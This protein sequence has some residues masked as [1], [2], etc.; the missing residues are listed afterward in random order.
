MKC[1]SKRAKQKTWDR[2]SRASLEAH[3]FVYLLGSSLV[4][5][6]F[7]VWIQLSFTG[8]F[9]R[10]PVPSRDAGGGKILVPDQ[11]SH[12]PENWGKIQ[13]QI[14]QTCGEFQWGKL[15]CAKGLVCAKKTG[16]AQG[17]CLRKCTSNPESCP[18]GLKCKTFASGAQGCLSPRKLSQ[19]GERCTAVP[20]EPPYLCVR[21]KGEANV[22][23]RLPCDPS[24][25]A[26]NAC[27]ESFICGV[28]STQG[29]SCVPKPAG[30]V[31]E[32]GRCGDQ[33]GQ[34]TSSPVNLLCVSEAQRSPAWGSCLRMCSTAQ[35]CPNGLHCMQSTKTC[36]KTCDRGKGDTDCPY[37]RCLVLPN[38]EGVS[39]CY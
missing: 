6:L 37:G 20:C 7:I 1:P 15:P 28:L 34:C 17:I 11:L 14:G 4:G 29:G 32:F 8:C 38:E 31:K 12:P 10:P 9:N 22:H 23:C 18:T 36:A 2:Y 35:P 26:P 3:R 19:L 24:P 21:S 33:D 27:P 39:V 30:T 16:L 5:T 25:Q 13:M